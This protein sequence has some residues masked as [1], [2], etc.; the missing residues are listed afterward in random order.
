M[1]GML[2]VDDWT[3]LMRQGRFGDAWKLS[4]AALAHP[5]GDPRS[6]PRHLQRIWNGA[7]LAG[8]RVLVRCYHGLGDTIQFVRYAPMLEDALEVTFWVQPQLMQ[9]LQGLEGVDR[10]LPL[11]DGSPDIAYDVDVEIMEL[12]HAFRTTLETIPARLPDLSAI[13]VDLPASAQ[14]RVGLAWQAGDWDR[15]RSIPFSAASRLLGVEN[16]AYFPLLPRLAAVEAAMFPEAVPAD[17]I[18]KLADLVSAL[19]L[20]ITVDTLVAHLAGALGVRTWLLLRTDPDWRWMLDRTD[21]P[22]YPATTLYR[23]TRPGD[24]ETVIARV[25][26]DLWS[27][28]RRGLDEKRQAAAPCVICS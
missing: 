28:A 14:W 18:M 1:V 27:L 12:P 22:W 7:A 19:D 21:T 16:V 23:Q 24:W 10:L 17:S 3:Q 20:V 13:P 5:R 26:H 8:R 2:A 9:L 15:A 11:H 25:K 4:D 6:T